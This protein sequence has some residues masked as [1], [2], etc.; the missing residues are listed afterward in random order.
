MRKLRL[1]ILGA[2]ALLSAAMLLGSL[3]QGLA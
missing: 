3:S 1:K 2:L